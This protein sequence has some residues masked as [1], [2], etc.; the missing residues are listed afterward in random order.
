MIQYHRL[1]SV[2][3]KHHVTH[4]E[5]GKLLMEQCM[6]RVGFDSTYSILYYRIPPTDESAVRSLELPGFCPIRPTEKQLLHR[7]H[8]K[9]QNLKVDGDFLT[10][11]R[12]VLMNADIRIGISKP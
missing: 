10:A 7:R 9:T 1:G 3:P 12:T 4:Y 11:R 5:D 8:I 2:P 6:T